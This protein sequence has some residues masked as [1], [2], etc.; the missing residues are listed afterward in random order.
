MIVE[1]YMSAKVLRN[2]EDL[3]KIFTYTLYF[4]HEESLPDTID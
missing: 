2:A 1:G 3:Q 4:D